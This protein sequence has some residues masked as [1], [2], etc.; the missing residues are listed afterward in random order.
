MNHLALIIVFVS[1]FSQTEQ[2]WLRVPQSLNFDFWLSSSGLRPSPLHSPYFKTPGPMV[3]IID[4][5][6]T[7]NIERNSCFR[8]GAVWWSIFGHWW[9]TFCIKSLLITLLGSQGTVFWKKIL[10]KSNTRFLTIFF[11]KIFDIF[12]DFFYGFSRFSVEVASAGAIWVTDSDSIGSTC[13]RTG[14][15]K[16]S[17]A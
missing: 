10:E 7:L 12:F 17:P 5:I 11:P 9:L 13:I 8:H 15:K 4:S 16:G 6:H 3:G 1:S 14:L 2:D